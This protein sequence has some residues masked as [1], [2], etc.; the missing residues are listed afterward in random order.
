M[1]TPSSLKLNRSLDR[2][3]VVRSPRDQSERSPSNQSERSPTP[4][5]QSELCPGNKSQASQTL[6]PSKHRES[7]RDLSSSEKENVD[8]SKDGRKR[9]LT[10]NTSL[11]FDSSKRQRTKERSDAETSFNSANTSLTS[12]Y[13]QRLN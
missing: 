12:T 4:R 11:T 13:R 6:S 5:D 1:N 7:S 10:F 3:G 8:S 9:S 2:L